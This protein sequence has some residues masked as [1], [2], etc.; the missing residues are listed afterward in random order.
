[1][2]QGVRRSM[3][4]MHPQDLPMP[5][6]CVLARASDVLDVCVPQRH[7]CASVAVVMSS[8]VRCVSMRLLMCAPS[9]ATVTA[10][11]L[12]GNGCQRDAFK[13]AQSAE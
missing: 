5:V 12:A 8:A 7:R 1:M 4:R 2:G 6:T 10:R 9:A 13:G 11:L 3:D